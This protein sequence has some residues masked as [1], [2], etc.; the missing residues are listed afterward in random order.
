[1]LFVNANETCRQYRVAPLGL[2]FVATATERAGHSVRFRDLPQTAYGQPRYHSGL[3]DWQPD[4]VA[5]SICN[6]NNSDY[7]A[8]GFK[9]ASPAKDLSSLAPISKT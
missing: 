9:R 5:L 4:Y 2:A 6:L 3:R 8:P 1:V 7:H